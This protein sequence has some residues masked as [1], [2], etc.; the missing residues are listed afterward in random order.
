[1]YSAQAIAKLLQVGRHLALRAALLNVRIPIADIRAGDL[2]AEIGFKQLRDLHQRFAIRAVGV[3]R[4]V[5]GPVGSWA[6]LLH[7][8]KRRQRLLPRPDQHTRPAIELAMRGLD[9][10]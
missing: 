9:L 2:Q 5:A 8:R 3:L 4:A 1:V 10:R 7:D 6:E